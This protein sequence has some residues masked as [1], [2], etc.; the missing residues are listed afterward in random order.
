LITLYLPDMCRLTSY[1]L[2]I[3]KSIYSLGQRVR[4][5]HKWECLYT[6]CTSLYSIYNELCGRVRVAPMYASR[7]MCKSH[8]IVWV[9]LYASRIWPLR[10]ALDFSESHLTFVS[11]TLVSASR[12]WLLGVAHDFCESHM[13]SASRPWVLRVA[14]EF[15]EPH[16]D[17]AS[18]TSCESHF[19]CA[20]R[21]SLCES[22]FM[23]IT[24]QLCESH[25]IVLPLFPPNP[26][27]REKSLSCAAK[28]QRRLDLMMLFI[29]ARFGDINIYID[30]KYLYAGSC[31][32]A[33]FLVKLPSIVFKPSLMPF[34]PPCSILGLTS[35]PTPS[36]KYVTKSH[37]PC[38]MLSP[39]TS[40]SHS[41][42]DSP[43]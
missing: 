21:L 13:T 29:I 17:C 37:N 33:P 24:F 38:T 7:T 32:D 8:F 43:P 10:V 31:I 11:R 30:C 40:Q 23:R 3:P 6:D 34:P 5:Y 14:N 12:T 4:S 19:N 41:K 15:C 16:F 22:H 26:P 28:I 36:R 2:S 42:I 35:L 39:R 1:T 25:F 9:A 27:P 20:S 18:H